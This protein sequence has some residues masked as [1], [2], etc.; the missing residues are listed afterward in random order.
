M[1]PI[2]FVEGSCAGPF[3]EERQVR[4]EKRYGIRMDSDFVAMSRLCNG[5]IPVLRYFDVG[6]RER[7]IDRFLCLLD[8]PDASANGHNGMYDVG[9]IR[10]M[11]SDRLRDWLIPFAELFAGDMLCFQYKAEYDQ[12]SDPD[13]DLDDDDKII[14]PLYPPMICVWDHE[15]SKELRPVLYPVADS[16]AQ[17]IDL[18]KEP[19]EN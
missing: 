4:M 9:V 2:A 18:L 12:E 14:D 5:G 19:Q 6:E 11:T 7:M 16:F 3:S 10:T 1:K 8:A 13:D 17:F 15:Q